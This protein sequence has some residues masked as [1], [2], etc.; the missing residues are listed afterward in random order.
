MGVV[1]PSS[2]HQP[3]PPRMELTTVRTCRQALAICLAWRWHSPLFLR[4]CFDTLPSTTAMSEESDFEKTLASIGGKERIYLVSDAAES[5]D[6]S[7]SDADVLREFIG[8]LFG[9]RRPFSSLAAGG[10]SHVC[11]K[12]DHKALPGKSDDLEPGA[13]PSGAQRTV[14]RQVS[15]SSRRRTIDCPAVVFLFRQTFISSEVCLKEVLK[16]VQARTK[17]ASGALPALIGLV[18]ITAGESDPDSRWYEQRLETLFHKVF[19]QHPADTIWVG[20]FVPGTPSSVLDIKRNACRVI[21]CAQTADI[22]RDN[23]N[24]LWWPFQC[25]FRPNRRGAREAANS[26]PTSKQRGDSGTVEESIPLKNNSM[27]A[28]PNEESVGADA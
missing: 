28:G 17:R 27:S 19:P 14:S 15:S 9:D 18:R 8:D 4:V 11:A 20:S 23:G 7:Q 1:L 13:R 26:P 24:P 6:A 10:Q 16:D 2:A 3:R 22:T 5:K 21:A 12:G 25:L